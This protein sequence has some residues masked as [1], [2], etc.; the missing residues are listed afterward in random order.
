MIHKRIKNIIEVRNLIEE[1]KVFYYCERPELIPRT[2]F[3]VVEIQHKDTPKPDSV[4]PDTY[5]PK[6]FVFD[7]EA[8][9]EYNKFL[10]THANFLR[11][12]IGRY[13]V[14]LSE[15]RWAIVYFISRESAHYFYWAVKNLMIGVHFNLIE[16]ALNLV[17]NF[18]G[19]SKNLKKGTLVAYS[20][21]NG[22]HDFFNEF[23]AI[24]FEREVSNAISRFARNQRHLFKSPLMSDDDK[25]V[26]LLI[27]RIPQDV[28]KNFIKKMTPCMSI[29]TI[30]NELRFLASNSILWDKEWVKT[31][32]KKNHLNVDIVFE[33]TNI[34]LLRVKDYYAIRRLGGSTS[35]CIT[36]KHSFWNSY[37]LDMPD[38]AE[39]YM[40]FNFALPEYDESSIVGFTETIGRGITAMHNFKNTSLMSRN[41]ELKQYYDNYANNFRGKI[42]FDVPDEDQQ[43]IDEILRS[44]HI[45]PDEFLKNIGIDSK[46]YKK[47]PSFKWEKDSV[48]RII[49]SIDNGNHIILRDEGN[50]LTIL[51]TDIHAMGVITSQIDSSDRMLSACLKIYRLDFNKEREDPESIINVSVN[52]RSLLVRNSAN[53]ASTTTLKSLLNECGGDAFTLCK[54]DTALER[55]LLCIENNEFDKA[56]EVIGSREF[57]K[58]YARAPEY[59]RDKVFG[60]WDTPRFAFTCATL[61]LTTIPF[62]HL[63][64]AGIPPSQFLSEYNAWRF[65]KDFQRMFGAGKNICAKLKTQLEFEISVFEKIMGITESV[66]TLQERVRKALDSAAEKPYASP[67]LRH[68]NRSRIG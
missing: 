51:V 42:L 10:K 11:T 37:Y 12:L 48:L 6:A 32:I 26:L 67:F 41:R 5:S 61:L 3:C 1:G 2:E 54:T 62:E 9:D 56:R 19:Y 35:W 30:I 16:R 22:L 52:D 24:I 29:P 33:G 57:A 46:S 40:V 53:E 17:F 58:E 15:T 28:A 8:L 18:R 65:L 68:Y 34:L 13:K 20:D 36:R 25:R 66:G 27:N 38:I 44:S 47:D 39:Q 7:T 31:F 4:Y 64:E 14:N 60:I 43:T 49:N 63:L 50:I 59:V 21:V 45:T 23:E 55:Y